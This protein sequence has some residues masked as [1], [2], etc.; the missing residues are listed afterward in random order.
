MVT[1]LY[2]I[3]L[4]EI[5][6]E[7]STTFAVDKRHIHIRCKGRKD[8]IQETLPM[9]VS[10]LAKYSKKFTIELKKNTPYVFSPT[11]LNQ[12]CVF[13]IVPKRFSQALPKLRP[14]FSCPSVIIDHREIR[15]V[16]KCLNWMKIKFTAHKVEILNPSI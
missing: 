13:W 6:N 4:D 11:R 3:E 12:L 7:D 1:Y 10:L 15:I 5:L 8:K 9:N 16:R 14:L 2:T